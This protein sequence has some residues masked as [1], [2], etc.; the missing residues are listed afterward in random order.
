MSTMQARSCATIENQNLDRA[1]LGLCAI[2]LV[3]HF[4]GGVEVWL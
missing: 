4:G 1:F 3:V 2:V